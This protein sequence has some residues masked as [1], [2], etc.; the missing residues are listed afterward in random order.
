VETNALYYGDNLGILREYIP[1]ESVDLVY[2]DPPFNSNR[3]YNVIFK[4]ESG[5]KSDAQIL[6]F[7]DTWHWGPDAE[8]QYSYLTNTALNHGK[9]PAPVSSTVA[10]LRHG[11]GENQMLAYIVEM[12][13]RLVELHRVLRPTGSLWL[14]CDPTASHYLRSCWTPS[15]GLRTSKTRLFGSEQLPTATASGR[16]RELADEL[17]LSIQRVATLVDGSRS[18]AVAAAMKILFP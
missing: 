7:E 13:V 5:R 12:A 10:A 9:V 15:S 4:D 8:S 14:H 17:G 3:D 18:F 11:I 6:A 1:N 16:L 2:L